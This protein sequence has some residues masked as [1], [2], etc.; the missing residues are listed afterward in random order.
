MTTQDLKPVVT[1]VTPEQMAGN[2]RIA[3]VLA[4]FALSVFAFFIYRQWTVSSH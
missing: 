2:R 4:L 3:I 1:K